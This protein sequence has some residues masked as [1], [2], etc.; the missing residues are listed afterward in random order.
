MGRAW[1]SSLTPRDD[2]FER[3]A[4]PCDRRRMELGCVDQLSNKSIAR[5]RPKTYSMRQ[6]KKIKL[7][8]GVLFTPYVSKMR[9]HNRGE[10][11]V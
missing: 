9:L 1:S 10:R 6:F 5:S 4:L 7:Q 8:D 3:S 11:G 2:Q